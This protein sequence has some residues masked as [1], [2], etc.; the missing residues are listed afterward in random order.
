MANVSKIEVISDW[1]TE[2]PKLNANF[3]AVNLELANLKNTRSIKIPLFSSTAEA[4]KNLPSPYVGQ[5]ILIGTSL[6][7]PIYK[8]NGN[9]WSNTGQTGGSAE[10]PLTNYYNKSEIDSRFQIVKSTTEVTI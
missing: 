6:P 9:A 10:V 7:A 5:L 2:A 3:N 8:W 4:S 1:G